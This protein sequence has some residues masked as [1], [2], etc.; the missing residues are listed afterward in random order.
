MNGSTDTTITIT[1][2]RDLA[3]TINNL[4]I[5]IPDA[6]GWSKTIGDISYSDMT[7]TTSISGDTIYFTDITFTSDST[8]ITI[9]NV[10]SPLYTGYYK[11]KVQSGVNGTYGDVSPIPT[12]TIYGA[13]VPIA[14]TK[15]NDAN[16]VA[17]L[18]GDLVTVRGIITVGNEFGSPSFI[19]DNS[20]GMSI[21][22]TIFSGSVIIGDEVLVSGRITQFNGLNQIEYPT[23]HS[24]LSQGNNVEP[25]LSTASQ[26][27]GDGIG[28]VENY[29]G[30]LVRLN[31]VTVTQLNGSPVT[32]WSSGTNYRLTG[33]S[34]NDTVQLRIDNNT[35]LVGNV[36]P[37]GP[38]DVIG[39][40]G[41]YKTSSPYTSGYQLMPRS[42]ADVISEGPIFTEFP[43]EIELAPTS[44][45]I[46]WKTLTAGTSRVQYGTTTAYELGIVE[47]HQDTMQTEHYVPITGLNPATIYNVQAFSTSGTDTAFASNLIVSTTSAPP[48]TGTINVYFNKS[49]NST[50]SSGEAALGN[51]DL[52]GKIVQRINN[53]KRSI[54]ASIY[55]LSGSPG[56]TVASALV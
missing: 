44:L 25:I 40:L 17:L 30:Q 43:Q 7:A 8:V 48:T 56:A 54:D 52:T 20:G 46:T 11:I 38:F 53:A 5:I 41:Q 16:G 9:L 28:G 21:Y 14:D 49:I 23:L 27:N 35:L 47:V 33:T 50:V 55:S 6:F 34:P 51:Y 42:P 4:R 13:A 3:F 22:G 39:V 29:E 26:L 37:A 10:T 12:M 36:A 45:A 32:T 31:G 18:I 1:Y 24:I 19:Q 15:V 2:R